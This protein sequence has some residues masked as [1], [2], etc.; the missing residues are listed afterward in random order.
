MNNDHSWNYDKFWAKA[1]VYMQ[2]ALDEEREGDLFPL[3]AAITLELVARASLANVHPALLADPRDG[4]NILYGFGYTTSPDHVPISIPTKTVFER[5][6]VIIPAFTPAEKNFCQQLTSRRNEELHSGGSGFNLYPTN[7]W[8]FN[9]YRTLRILLENQGKTLKDLLGKIEAD[10]AEEMIAER[11]AD[12]EKTVHDRIAQFKKAFQQLSEPDQQVRIIRANAARRGWMGF[13]RYAQC[14]ACDQKAMLTGKLI[15]LSEG[16]AMD[17]FIVQQRNILPTFFICYCCD[18]QLN[19][20]AELDVVK[21]GG[22]YS[23]KEAYDPKDY[24]DISDQEPDFDYGN[25]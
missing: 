13:S 12:L 4:K 20:H 17:D 6:E 3:W 8:L 18:L 16:K 15:S 24:F 25:D 9:Y 23:V 19:N 11:A 7:Q 21:L 10:A 1:R 14:P 5:C 2:R 22:Q